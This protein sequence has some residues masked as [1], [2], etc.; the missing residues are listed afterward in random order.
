VTH[1]ATRLGCLNSQV[2]PSEFLFF[3][4]NDG[5]PIV[6]NQDGTINSPDHPT[7]SGSTVLLFG[8]GAG[9]TNT[10]AAVRRLPRLQT[11][12]ANATI[13]Y[14]GPAPAIVAGV[15]QVNVQVPALQVSGWLSV[16]FAFHWHAVLSPATAFVSVRL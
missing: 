1:S 14:V 4:S 12:L 10:S 8:T 11:Q 16:N 5:S 6:V 15:P 13:A 2:T 7:T 9:T 3:A